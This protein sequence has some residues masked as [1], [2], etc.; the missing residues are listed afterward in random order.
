MDK[1]TKMGVPHGSILGPQLFL[2][3]MDDMLCNVSCKTVL[4]DDNTA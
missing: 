3:Y 1:L 4:Y 2:I